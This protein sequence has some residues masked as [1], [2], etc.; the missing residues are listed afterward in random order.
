M[1]GWDNQKLWKQDSIRQVFYHQA[2]WDETL[3]QVTDFSGDKLYHKPEV[4][5]K[6]LVPKS[7]GLDLKDFSKL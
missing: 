4:D 3:R 7:T 1:F 5:Y 6:A 2:K